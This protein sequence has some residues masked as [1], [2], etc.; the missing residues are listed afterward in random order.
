MHFF[1]MSEV[2]KISRTSFRQELRRR[3]LVG[4]GRGPEP[5][6]RGSLEARELV[7]L[8]REPQLLGDHRARLPFG[9]HLHVGQVPFLRVLVPQRDR[10]L[11]ALLVVQLR[12]HE[13]VVPVV[14]GALALL[15]YDAAHVLL[16][17]L[18]FL[19]H[20]LHLR[21][22]FGRATFEGFI[23]LLDSGQGFVGLFEKV[24]KLC[25]GHRL[26]FRF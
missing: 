24:N 2:T 4:R 21:G 22:E 25:F 19:V 20:R 15:L 16:D 11:E 7:L 13:T 1:S 10:L 14:G 5:G 23:F 8:D 17:V 12:G 3:P 26:S 6:L 18:V 9:D